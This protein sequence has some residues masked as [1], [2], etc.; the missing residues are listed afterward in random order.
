MSW[1]WHK[2][3]DN[4]QQKCKCSF[5][6]RD[7]LLVLWGKGIVVFFLS[8][9][10]AYFRGFLVVGYFVGFC[11]EWGSLRGRRIFFFFKVRG[12]CVGFGGHGDCFEEGGYIAVWWGRELFSGGRIFRWFFGEGYWFVEGGYFAVFGERSLLKGRIYFAVFLGRQDCF[13]EEEYFVVFWG[14]WRIFC[15]FWVGGE[16]VWG[17]EDILL[18]FGG[19]MDCFGWLVGFYGI[20]TIIGYLTPNTF[21]YK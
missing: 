3:F 16:I 5:I 2:V 8:L 14:S 10:G 18:V 6:W 1:Q 15:W 4:I 17:R 20:S 19:E 21:L 7:I 9:E 12:Y 11:G 13:G